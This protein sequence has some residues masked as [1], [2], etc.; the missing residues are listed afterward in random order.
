MNWGVSLKYRD[1][2]SHPPVVIDISSD[3]FA[4]VEN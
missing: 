1:L 4:D 3:H 2:P